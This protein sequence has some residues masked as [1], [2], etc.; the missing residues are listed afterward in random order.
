MKKFDE[1]PD[2]FES[3]A[4]VREAEGI[5]KAGNYSLR[6]MSWLVSARYYENINYYDLIATALTFMKGENLCYKGTFLVY[7]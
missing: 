2:D 4:L 5:H 1:M 6:T 7:K 3:N